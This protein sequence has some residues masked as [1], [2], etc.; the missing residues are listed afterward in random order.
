MVTLDMSGDQIRDMAQYPECMW[1]KS[2]PFHHLQD[3]GPPRR[4]T[5]KQPCVCL[6]PGVWASEASD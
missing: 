1:A 5:W 6:L 3:L 2:A 4:D